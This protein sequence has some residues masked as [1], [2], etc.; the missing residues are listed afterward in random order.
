M[1]ASAG[2]RRAFRRRGREV[3]FAQTTAPETHK[4]AQQC[5]NIFITVSSPGDEDSSASQ[6]PKALAV[7]GGML[8][9]LTSKV[10]LPD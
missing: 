4:R 3:T 2:Q 10:V 8:A 6:A 7:M 5:S 1:G 9:V